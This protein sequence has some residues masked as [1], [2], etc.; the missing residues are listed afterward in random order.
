MEIKIALDLPSI[1]A[2]AVTAEK[3]QPLVD[4]AISDTIKEAIREA[5]DYSSEFRKEV[6]KQLASALPHGLAIDDMA[7]FQQVLNQA[8][9]EAVH[10]ENAAAMRTALQK[11]VKSVLPD[12]PEVLK[13]SELMVAA[14]EGFHK[15]DDRSEFYGHFEESEYGG[16]CIYLDSDPSP[17]YLSSRAKAHYDARHHIS[18]NKEGVV[19]ALKL[20]NTQL[21]PAAQPTVI[22]RF[23]S[24]LMA[25]YVGRTRL[26][27]DLDPNEV[28]SAAEAQY[29]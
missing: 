19:Y 11:A 25:M 1:I 23:E 4:K 8:L 10:G 29:D 17:G 2:S 9:S 24:I 6:K 3:L 12:A 15:D 18:F 27:V 5:T 16:G 22:T 21:T 28:K 26:D 7:K 20:N 14:R 13:L